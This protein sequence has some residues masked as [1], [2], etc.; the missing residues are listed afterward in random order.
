MIDGILSFGVF[1]YVFFCL[2]L[3]KGHILLTSKWV[4]NENHSAFG[5]REIKKELKYVLQQI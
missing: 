3:S 1:F 5:E 2:K 4:R